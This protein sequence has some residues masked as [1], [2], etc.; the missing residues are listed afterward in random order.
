MSNYC[1][2]FYIPDDA[3][4]PDDDYFSD[5]RKRK[6]NAEKKGAKKGRFEKNMAL[7]WWRLQ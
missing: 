1:G 2:P 3:S 7:L 4:N 5:L 6:A